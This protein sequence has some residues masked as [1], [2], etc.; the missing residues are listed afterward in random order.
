MA[1]LIDFSQVVLSSCYAYSDELSVKSKDKENAKNIVRH[2]ILNQLRHYN[3]LYREKFGKLIICCD[4][5][6]YWRREL[7]KHYKE[8]R[9][10]AR[11]ESDLDWKL[12]FD[13]IDET[14][15]DLKENFMFPLIRVNRAEGDDVIAVLTKHFQS[16]EGK[17]DGFFVIPQNILIVSSDKDLVQLQKYENVSQ[18]SPRNKKVVSEGNPLLYLKEKIIR[19]DRGDGIPSILNDED[20]YVTEGKKTV[21]MSKKR[22]EM[23]FESGYDQC[24][25]DKVKNRWDMNRKLIDF[26]YIPKDIEKTIVNT[27]LEPIS[28]NR[29]K[30]FNYMLKYNLHELLKVISDFNV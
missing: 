8:G 21:V 1:I 24:T 27:Y 11:A 17:E 16:N 4:G 29:V 12:I 5:K 28:G 13:I 3:S 15:T 26:D 25:D 6:H 20:L 14:I 9:K 23:L 2:V 30:M 10:K 18:I 22:F 19:G 7:F